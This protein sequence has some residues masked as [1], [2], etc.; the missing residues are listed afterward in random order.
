MRT[1]RLEIAV[2]SG[3]LCAVASLAAC[4][5]PPESP[6]NGLLDGGIADAAVA[7]AS[8]ADASAPDAVPSD[9]T[10]Y[11]CVGDVWASSPPEIASI[12][13]CTTITGSVYLNGNASHFD[14]PLLEEVT[15]DLVIGGAIAS[16]S[17]PSLASVGGSLTI[18]DS[19]GLSGIT[20]DSLVAVGE[21]LAVADNAG[22]TSLELGGVSVASALAIYDNPDLASVALDVLVGVD[23]A[24]ARNPQLVSVALAGTT[25]STVL[26]E[27]NGM[28]ASTPGT[29]A[30]SGS[31]AELVV[32][33][34][35]IS[36][37]SVT[38]QSSPALEIIVEDNTGAMD[39][40]I[41]MDQIRSLDASR[42]MQMSSLAFSGATLT[43]V[44]IKDNVSMNDLDLGALATA[45]YIEVHGN[46]LTTLSLGALT[47][48]QNL[49]VQES[50]SLVFFSMNVLPFVQNLRINDNPVLANVQSG[51]L[52]GIG[53]MTLSN[54][55]TLPVSTII[56][57][58]NL[59]GGGSVVCP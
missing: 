11:N 19:S 50:P 48:A 7:D 31:Q 36:E 5:S 45:D 1:V 21:S 8:L 47:C 34:S 20:L 43:T 49:R 14:L 44:T 40:D 57:L 30:I 25:N 23:L 33:S 32:R 28:T 59:V 53:S 29:Y 24:I 9:A 39:V 4:Q 37:L 51:A 3:T 41:A 12:R 54:N 46:G 42:N 35:N 58:N 22:I 52:E 18:E 56:A 15:G 16:I 2:L 6:N 27:D 55:P 10:P 13:A 38:G 17:L 26:L